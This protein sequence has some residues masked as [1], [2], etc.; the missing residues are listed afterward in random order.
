MKKDIKK[1]FIIQIGG[2]WSGPGGKVESQH[3]EADLEFD[4]QEIEVASAVKGE[5]LLAKVKHEIRAALTNVE[6]TIKRGCVRCLKSFK[7]KVKIPVAERSFLDRAPK[8]KTDLD[9]IFLIN[10]KDLSIDLYD[11]I[12]QEIILHFPLISVC[13][14]SCK[15]LCP[16][17]G[18]DRNRKTCKCKEVDEGAQKPFKNLKKLIK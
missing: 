10:L 17:C 2:L 11:M 16:H 7:Q 15:G 18:A 9:D 8:D 13:S 3:F 4:P 5:M 6:V 12:R 1:S 14:K